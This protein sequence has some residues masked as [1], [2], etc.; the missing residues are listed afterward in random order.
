MLVGNHEVRHRV[1]DRHRRMCVRELFRE[2]GTRM[3]VVLL[4]VE[5][6]MKPL[7]RVREVLRVLI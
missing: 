4:S 2:V 3:Q 5:Q 1:Q 7:T 6:G